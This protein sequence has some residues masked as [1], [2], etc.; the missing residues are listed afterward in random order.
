[1]KNI[2]AGLATNCVRQ[3]LAEHDGIVAQLA[4]IVLRDEDQVCVNLAAFLGP[5]AA[6]RAPVAECWRALLLHM[7]KQRP[8][9][10]LERRATESHRNSFA[11]WM[12]NLRHIFGD[13]HLEPDGVK[14][15][16]RERIMYWM[17]RTM[18]VG[19]SVSSGSDETT[20]SAG[21]G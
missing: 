14:G 16:T 6:A 20:L 19:R 8:V 18:A 2:P 9:G 1:V 17:G 15:F 11:S 3:S 12:Q 5:R 10:L 21:A 7:M 4:S 13:R